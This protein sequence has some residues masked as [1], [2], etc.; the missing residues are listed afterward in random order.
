[1]WSSPAV[2]TDPGDAQ[3]ARCCATDGHAGAAPPVARRSQRRLSEVAHRKGSCARN[4]PTRCWIRSSFQ[5]RARSSSRSIG[6]CLGWRYGG[7]SANHRWLKRLGSG[8]GA[9]ALASQ[10]CNSSRSAAAGSG[11]GSS[12]PRRTHHGH[13]DDDD[14]DIVPCKLSTRSGTSTSSTRR[15]TGS[16]AMRSSG[17][18]ST[19]PLLRDARRRRRP[20]SRGRIRRHDRS[21]SSSLRR[22]AGRHLDLC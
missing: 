19:L 2:D 14:A 17:A 1:M 8:K 9:G 16:T 6:T 20:G 15:P 10:R 4:G 3:P 13:W 22:A 12:R 5:P 18:S 7:L 11:A 21:V